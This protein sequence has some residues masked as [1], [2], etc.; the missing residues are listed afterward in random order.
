MER[1]LGERRLEAATSLAL[2]AIVSFVFGWS[3]W[4]FV[5]AILWALVAAIMFAPLDAWFLARL[6]D[7]PGAAAGLTVLVIALAVVLPTIA[8]AAVLVDQAAA[9]YAH[10]QGGQVDVAGTFENA[11]SHLP[12]WAQRALTRFGVTDFASFSDK[13]SAS[14]GAQVRTMLIKA[15]AIGSNAA[16]FVLSVVLM[17]YLAYYLL[18]GGEDL[19]RSVGRAVPLAPDERGALADRFVTVVRATVK[20]SVIVGLAQGA[21]GGVIMALLG[22][23]H[24]L[25]W[26]VLMAFSSLLPAVGTGLVWVPASLYLLATGSTWQ[27]IVMALAGLFVIG[28]VDN[29]LRPILVGRETKIPDALV[30]VTTLG[31]LESFGFN[32]LL[33][34]P[35]ATA[36]FLTMWKRLSTARRQ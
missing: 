1:S 24:A 20:G 16:G 36:L 14:I 3:L 18:R 27:G 25:L 30:L 15:L 28:S 33:I 31:G 32:G 6:P 21:L 23:P 11:R 7:R 19:A 22:V 35:V 5:G 13:V 10:V 26:A 29:V 12:E 34:G 4:P 17:L 8:L 2:L 9:L